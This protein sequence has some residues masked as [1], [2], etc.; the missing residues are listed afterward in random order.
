MTAKDFHAE[1]KVGG[2]VEFAGQVILIKGIVTCLVSIAVEN[3][4]LAQVIA[5]SVIAV[6]AQEGVV[7]VE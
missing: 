6:A 1:I 3:A 7:Q 2:V 4:P 5:P